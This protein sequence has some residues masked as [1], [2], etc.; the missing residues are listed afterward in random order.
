MR[1]RLIGEVRFPKE[2][3]IV[4]GVEKTLIVPSHE[5][6]TTLTARGLR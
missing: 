4:L 2:P 3:Q 6:S 5:R 1:L